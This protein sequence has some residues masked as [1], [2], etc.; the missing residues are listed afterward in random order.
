MNWRMFVCIACSACAGA[1]TSAQR[2][3]LDA[4]VEIEHVQ[5]PDPD[6]SQPFWLSETRLY[7]DIER[8]QLATDL[9]A[10]EPRFAL[11]S[12]GAEKQRWLRLPEGTVIDSSDPEHWQFPVGTMVFKEFALQGKRL[13]TRL[14]ART[15]PGRDDYWMGAFAWNEDES[16]ARWLPDGAQN[17]RGTEH[18]IPKRKQCF[19]CHD[20]EPGRVLGFSALQKPDVDRRRLTHTVP[21]LALHDELEALGYLHANCAHCHNPSGSARPDTD[22]NLRL[23]LDAAHPEDTA[24]YRTTVGV[25][26]QYFEHTGAEL[27][28]QA[29]GAAHSGV[30]VRM[31]D[32]GPETQM[33]PLATEQVDEVGI[34]A[35]RAWIERL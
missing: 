5:L 19:T 3:A 24:T 11:W 10:F 29:G 7:R 13:E 15:G 30:I 1:E 33:P 17:V 8:K 31:N 14:I 18:D 21:E 25:A 22:M 32:R 23:S 34:R 16:D 20:G 26:M 9:Y 35:V 2:S 27:R 12:D 4:N 28:V 6:A